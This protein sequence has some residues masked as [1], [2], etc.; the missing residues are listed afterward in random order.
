MAQVCRSCAAA[1]KRGVFSTRQKC[2]QGVSTC[3]LR[4]Y[5]PPHCCPLCPVPALHVSSTQGAAGPSPARAPTAAA[6]TLALS[7]GP[8]PPWRQHSAGAQPTVAAAGAICTAHTGATCSAAVTV[9][10]GRRQ[11]GRHHQAPPKRSS[12]ISSAACNTGVCSQLSVQGGMCRGWECKQGAP[13]SWWV[14]M[15]G[16]GEGKGG[17]GLQYALKTPTHGD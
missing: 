8:R 10:T 12:S 4:S 14:L 11:Q 7:A 3:S 13:L 16:Q 5:L 17:R 9:C 1:V 15:H 6:V 2:C